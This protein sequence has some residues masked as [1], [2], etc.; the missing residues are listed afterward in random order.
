MSRVADAEQAGARPLFEAI[1]PDR[2]QADVPVLQFADAVKG[3]PRRL[4]FGRWR[5]APAKPDGARRA[6][7]FQPTCGCPVTALTFPCPLVHCSLPGVYQDH[8]PEVNS[9]LY[10]DANQMIHPQVVTDPWS[11]IRR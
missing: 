4:T 6:A 7:Y 1:D 9:G 11:A 8:L 10:Q 2:E 5:S 3:P